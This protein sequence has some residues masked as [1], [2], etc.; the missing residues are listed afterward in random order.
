MNIYLFLKDCI[1]PNMI[2]ISHTHTLNKNAHFKTCNYKRC[3]SHAHPYNFQ[4]F[5]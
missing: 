1:M 3:T 5:W 2:P 4:N